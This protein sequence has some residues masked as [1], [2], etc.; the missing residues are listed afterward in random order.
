M[1]ILRSRRKLCLAARNFKTRK[2]V[3]ATK[4]VPRSAKNLYHI[5]IETQM[6]TSAVALDHAVIA[7]TNNN[8][9][10]MSISRF[11][12]LTQ[13]FQVWHVLPQHQT[14]SCELVCLLFLL[15]EAGFGEP[16][17]QVWLLVVLCQFCVPFLVLWLARPPSFKLLLVLK[18]QAR[19]VLKQKTHR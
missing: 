18:R 15:I 11:S 1:L 14:G 6:N 9:N 7:K 16:V 13:V 4:V 3:H 2:Y 5:V 12:R 17:C 8:N 10:K 19:E